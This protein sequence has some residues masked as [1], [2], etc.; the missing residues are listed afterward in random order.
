M[1][2]FVFKVI[3]TTAEILIWLSDRFFAVLI[4]LAANGAG[5]SRWLIVQGSVGLMWLVSKERLEEAQEELEAQA[6]L[7]QQ[8]TELEL[9]TNASKLKEHALKNGDWTDDHTEALQAIGNAL[10]NDCDWDEEHVHQYL[11]EVVEEGTG[12]TYGLEYDDE[13]D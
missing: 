10:L 1:I 11:K 13:D 12:L 7:D 6:E 5:I 2:N 9:L 3:A 8:A 4:W